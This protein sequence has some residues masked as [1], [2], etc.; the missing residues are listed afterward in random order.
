M[1][2]TQKEYAKAASAY[3]KAT[4]LNPEQAY[5]HTQLGKAYLHLKR[6]S[7]AMTAF[8]RA[9]E[10]APTAST[11]NSIAYELSLAR[12]DLPRAQRYAESAV[13]SQSA[14]SRDLDVTRA[15]GRALQMAG[16]LSSYWD[17]LGWV[18][19]ANGELAAAEKYVEAAW[20]VAQ[21][22]EVGDHLGQI[23]EKTG[24]KDAAI[25]AYARA[26]GA[27]DPDPVVR[28]HLVNLIGDA[29][30]AQALIDRHR[31]DLAAARTFALDGKGPRGKKADFLLLFA[32]PGPV[33]AVKFVEGDEEMRALVP[34]VQKLRP[35]AFPESTPAKLLR[36]GLAA[37][38]PEGVCSIT[39]LLPEDARPVK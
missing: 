22:A 23:Y 35:F 19:F 28:E 37:C 15:D 33:E 1:Y 38:N 31:A 18:H 36:R 24:R 30:K 27:A 39:L 8:A 29:S 2:L 21:H 3:E 32:S 12:V 13:S 26:L 14:A 20:A 25:A 9:V 7:D 34:A 6:Q 16:S 5:A 17:T 4:A 10:L 11:W